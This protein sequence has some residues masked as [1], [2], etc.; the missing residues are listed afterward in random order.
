MPT[1]GKAH[2]FAVFV[3]IGRLWTLV[4]FFVVL[5]LYSRVIIM[6]LSFFSV[7]TNKLEFSLVIIVA[8][9]VVWGRAIENQIVG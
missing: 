9:N 8:A 7:A 3:Y 5:C 1:R 2:L 6:E 4:V